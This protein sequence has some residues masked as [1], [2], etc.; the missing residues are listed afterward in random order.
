MLIFILGKP[1]VA[2]TFHLNLTNSS[3]MPGIEIAAFTPQDLYPCSSECSNER[4]PCPNC[5][6]P[7]PSSSK[8]ADCHLPRKP[9]RRV[10]SHFLEAVR[11]RLIDDIVQASLKKPNTRQVKRY[12]GGFLL[13]PPPSLSE[14]GTGWEHHVQTRLGFPSAIFRLFLIAKI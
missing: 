8:S 6:A 13:G 2:P 1:L 7:L 3:G 11:N 12:K 10:Y 14:W 4:M 5:L 9:L